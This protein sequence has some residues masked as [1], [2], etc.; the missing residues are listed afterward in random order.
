MGATQRHI[1]ATLP[2]TVRV[3]LGP[4]DGAARHAF[5]HHWHHTRRDH[6]DHNYAAMFP[7]VDRLFGTLWWPAEYGTDTE[8]GDGLGAKLTRPFI[9]PTRETQAA[10]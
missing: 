1:N 2:A 6:V 3:R 7:F 4:Y 8:V 5:S 9:P 10:E